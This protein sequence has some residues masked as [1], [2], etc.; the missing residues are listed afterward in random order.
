MDAHRPTTRRQ[1]LGEINGNLRNEN[2]NNNG[3]AA[4]KRGYAIFVSFVVHLHLLLRCRRS[5]LIFLFFFPFRLPCFLT[6]KRGTIKSP[7]EREREKRKEGA[8]IS[9]ITHAQE[10]NARIM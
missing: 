6:K 1:A 3:K 2:N 7:F 10:T 9:F 5:R 4:V 8:K